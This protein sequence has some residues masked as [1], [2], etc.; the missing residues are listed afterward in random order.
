M[1]ELQTFDKKLIQSDPIFEQFKDDLA[2]FSDLKKGDGIVVAV[3]GGM[4]SMALLLLLD[5]IH[6]FELFVAH[7]NHNLRPDSD[8]DEILVRG[9][10]DV[11]DFPFFST[12]LNPDQ[13]EKG[14]SVEEW[15]RNHRYRFFNEV[16]EKTNC[17]WIMTAHHGNDQAETVL[18]NL[19]RQSG[20]S[21][22][23]GIG[24]QNGN[25][26]RPLLGFTK[27]K[28]TDFAKRTGI[29]FR[30]D[31][32]NSDLSIP[33][34]FIRHILVKPWENNVQNL[35]KGIQGSIEHFSEW[36]E[37]LDHFIFELIIPK[38]NRSV[39]QFEIPLKMIQNLPNMARVRLVQLLMDASDHELWSKHQIEQLKSFFQKNEIGNKHIL[40]N[41]WRLLRDR[42]SIIGKEMTP[43]TKKTPVELLPDHPVDFNQYRYE[44]VLAKQ[45]NLDSA[46]NREQV[47]WSLLKDHK[48][49]IRSWADGDSF[50]PLGMAG[51][52][53]ISDFLINE[54]VD[55][56][57]KES[58][59][60]L[61]ANGD[62]VWVCGRRIADWVKL[63]DKTKETAILNRSQIIA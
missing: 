1:R 46:Q 39:N 28:L 33:R 52:Q 44:L 8:K 60:V 17:K 11:L 50:Q 37:A 31:S 55:R 23:C 49:E 15:A 62:I 2:S 63:T 30:E 9:I 4:D 40:P 21:G 48:L 32:T 47:D 53:K 51:H 38:V 5:T 36:M 45:S 12:S 34:N 35:V 43:Q 10:C 6:E 7:V 3:S 19:S 26:V 22:L 27:K 18:M 42:T 57:A 54:K 29:P 14:E 25:V 59:A 13:I 20:I 61:T 56:F 24:K 16:L 41:G 58:Q